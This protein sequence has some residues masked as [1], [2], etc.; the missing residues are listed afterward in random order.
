MLKRQLTFWFHLNARHTESIT[1]QRD[2][3][4]IRKSEMEA[5]NEKII[6][7]QEQLVKRKVMMNLQYR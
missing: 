2:L 6:K 3:L 5:L 1:E 7:M 4:K